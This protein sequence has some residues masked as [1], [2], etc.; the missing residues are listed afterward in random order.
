ME[1]RGSQWSELGSR[2]L[3]NGRA[4]GLSGDLIGL[5]SLACLPWGESYDILRHISTPNRNME[6]T[7][8][9]DMRYADAMLND[10]F[11]LLSF[12][13]LCQALMGRIFNFSNNIPLEIFFT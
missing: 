11:S 12:M 5:G 7:T 1:F 8:E 4:V 10:S 3:K 2:C 13:H 9:T 6:N